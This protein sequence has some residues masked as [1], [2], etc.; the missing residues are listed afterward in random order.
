MQ[1]HIFPPSSWLKIV[2]W[3]HNMQTEA[4]NYQFSP[5]RIGEKTIKKD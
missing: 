2:A 3:M 1:F 5:L 4:V